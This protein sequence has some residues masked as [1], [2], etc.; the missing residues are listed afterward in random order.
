MQLFDDATMHGENS[1]KIYNTWE[2]YNCVSCTN[3]SS[4]L[5]TVASEDNRIINVILYPIYKTAKVYF[6]TKHSI[7][8]KYITNKEPLQVITKKS[9]Q[10]RIPTNTSFYSNASIKIKKVNH[11]HVRDR[12]SFFPYR[13]YGT[14]RA[15]PLQQTMSI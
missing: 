10:N 7:V 9:Q 15:T 11:R 14:A 2:Y 6:C 8:N 3:I 12:F 4:K 5:D 13:P 1:Y